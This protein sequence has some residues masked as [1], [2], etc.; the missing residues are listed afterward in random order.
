MKKK[1]RRENTY[2]LPLTLTHTHTH[3][4][5]SSPFKLIRFSADPF[6]RGNASPIF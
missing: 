3:T 1:E 6:Q 5:L 2:T 4:D